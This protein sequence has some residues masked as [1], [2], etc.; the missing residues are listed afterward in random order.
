MILDRQDITDAVEVA[1]GDALE[2]NGRKPQ[3]VSDRAV[4]RQL[5]LFLRTISEL[6]SDITI[7]E[8]REALDD[9]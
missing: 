4:E 2:S 5:V 3:A 8:L 1:L 6:P 9:L 7:E